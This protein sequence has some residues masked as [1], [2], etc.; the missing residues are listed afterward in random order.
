M[1]IYEDHIFG[2]IYLSDRKL[3][4]EELYCEQCNDS[5]WYIGEFDSAVE[6]LKHLADDIDANDGHGGYAIDD[7]LKALKSFDDVPSLEE[8]IGIVK[9]NRTEEE[10]EKENGASKEM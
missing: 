3:T 6:L 5:D 1:F 10:K 2:D 7:L 8:A 4:S 9:T